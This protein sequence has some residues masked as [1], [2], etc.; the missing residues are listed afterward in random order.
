M[1]FTAVS[2]YLVLDGDLRFALVDCPRDDVVRR[3]L[4]YV[5]KVTNLK[6]EQEA[7]GMDSFQLD[8][9]SE[10]EVTAAFCSH[11]RQFDRQEMVNERSGKQLSELCINKYL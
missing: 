2:G 10:E 8:T 4:V 7:R 1:L 5:R 3:C 6:V 9:Q 11:T